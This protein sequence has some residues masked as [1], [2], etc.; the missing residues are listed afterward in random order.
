MTKR[1]YC[2]FFIFLVCI[3]W[4]RSSTDLD[5]IKHLNENFKEILNP[6]NLS[7]MEGT[8]Q[9]TAKFSYKILEGAVSPSEDQAEKGADQNE[10]L[11]EH[12]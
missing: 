10:D 9:E 6:N 3:Q 2:H 7:S 4:R 11:V 5:I 8:S 12:G 1:I